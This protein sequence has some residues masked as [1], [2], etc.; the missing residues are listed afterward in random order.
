MQAQHKAQEAGPAASVATKENA[1]ATDRGAQVEQHDSAEQEPDCKA[2][3]ALAASF[4]RCGLQLRQLQGGRLLMTRWG[5]AREFAGACDAA[6]FLRQ[7]GGRH[8]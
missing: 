6:R 4:E 5:M 8:G 2:F 1:P 3:A 7:I